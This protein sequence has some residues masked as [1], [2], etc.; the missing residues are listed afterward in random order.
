MSTLDVAAEILR[1]VAPRA[2]CAREIAERAGARLPTA[3]RTPQTV[4]SRDLAIDVRDR[5]AASRFLRV[6]RG[7]FVLKEALPTAFY[8]D[9]DAYAAQWTRNLVTAGEIAP[10]VVDERSIR[11]LK[12]TDVASYRQC[13]FF[14][15]IGTWSRALRDAGWSDDVPVWTGSCPCQPFSQAGRKAGFND[16]QHL[17]PEWFRLI[18]AC[19]PPVIFAEQV[20]SKD[21]LAWL[22]VVFS[23]LEGE[24]YAV[25]AIDTCAAGYGSPH[26][27]QRLYIVAIAGERGW[28][29]VRS[30]RLHDRRQPGDDLARRRPADLGDAERVPDAAGARRASGEDAGADRGDERQGPEASEWRSAGNLELERS[31]APDEPRAISDAERDRRVAGRLDRAH[32]WPEIE[33]DRHGEV[34]GAGGADAVV[35]ADEER[36]QGREAGD[37]EAWDGRAAVGG[38]DDGAVELGDAGLAR[39]GR[40]AGALSRAERVGEGERIEPRDL[41]HEPVTSS[42]D[43]FD[44]CVRGVWRFSNWIYC[45]PVPGHENGRWRPIEPV[46]VKIPDGHPAPVGTLSPEEVAD[47]DTAEADAAQVLRCLWPEA[48]TQTHQS[49]IGGFG[50]IQAA[51]VLRPALHGC[52][53]GGKNQSSECAEL[54]TA[55][56]ETGGQVL[57]PLRSFPQA[58]PRASQGRES[59][60]QRAV[61]PTDLVRLLSSSL[62]F[63]QFRSDDRTTEALQALLKSCGAE[64]LV[65]RPP[66]ETAEVWGS[67]PDTDK[68]RFLVCLGQFRRASVSPLAVEQLSKTRAKRLRGYGNAIVLPLAIEFVTAV[69][70]T[71]ADAAREVKPV[72]VSD[73]AWTGPR[74]DDVAPSGMLL[75]RVPGERWPYGPPSAHESGCNLFPHRGSPGGLFCDCAASAADDVEYGVGT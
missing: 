18:K 65:S 50:R 67:L 19:R 64:G 47:V 38:C 4:V 35:D 15:G 8:N 66:R 33:P 59:F 61:E 62:A 26:L 49:E 30:A 24:G 22:D 12:P 6:D 57:F 56:R 3:S 9:N 46:L 27:R 25:R 43:F 51:E 73:S 21:G 69:I 11:D 71:L 63:S 28:E 23:N 55:E 53:H 44:S 37:D 39:G 45:R 40:D 36:L 32:G 7:E 60:E 2:L 14:S 34:D 20:A 10:G 31:G 16:D 29:V 52:W 17:W 68:I 5:G 54:A 72:P 1:E 58:L 75:G 70:E 13:H 42:A 48:G 41:T 74:S